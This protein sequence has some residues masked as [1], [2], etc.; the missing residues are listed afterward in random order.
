MHTVAGWSRAIAASTAFSTPMG[1]PVNTLVLG[2]GAYR[3]R[4][5]LVFGLPLQLL[6]NREQ[7]P[8][9][10][11]F[12]K[13]DNRLGS[14]SRLVVMDLFDGFNRRFFGKCYPNFRLRNT[15]PG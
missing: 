4:D 13:A 3:F 7:L 5:Y 6:S 1:S 2:A 12:S 10:V 15:H 9:A 8:Q 14:E 11:P